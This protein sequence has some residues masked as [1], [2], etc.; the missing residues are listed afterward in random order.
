MKTITEDFNTLAETI[1]TV[2]EDLDLDEILSLLR[3]VAKPTSLTS[4]PF[5]KVHHSYQMRRSVYDMCYDV[6]YYII[7][8]FWKL[9]GELVVTFIE[10]TEGGYNYTPET[11]EWTLPINDFLHMIVGLD[12]FYHWE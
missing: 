8:R 1:V 9:D 6:A 3:F 10:R 7:E 2:F 5:H 11:I 12:P 4:R